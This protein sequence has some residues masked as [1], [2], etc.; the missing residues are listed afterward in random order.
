MVLRLSDIERAFLVEA[1]RLLERVAKGED[2]REEARRFVSAL[3]VRASGDTDAIGRPLER[4]NLKRPR[5]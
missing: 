5:E 4:V 3:E 1:V 2:V